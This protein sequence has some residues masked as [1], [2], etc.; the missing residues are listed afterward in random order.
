MRNPS[1]F[2]VDTADDAAW[3]RWNKAFRPLPAERPT[4]G[5]PGSMEKIRVMI[6]RIHAGEE[7]FHPQD[8]AAGKYE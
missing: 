4:E 7:L 6:E 1:L 5:A 8:Y 3:R 2:D